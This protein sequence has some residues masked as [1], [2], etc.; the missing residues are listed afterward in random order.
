[1]YGVSL[2]RST[3]ALGPLASLGHIPLVA[4]LAQ[5]SSVVP[6]IGEAAKTARSPAWPRSLATAL[7]RAPAGANF[8]PSR[9][10]GE[11]DRERASPGP[12]RRPNR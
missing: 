10:A 7:V 1:M 4:L 9:A 12:Q 2:P 5:G 11:H 8:G 6:V 3:G